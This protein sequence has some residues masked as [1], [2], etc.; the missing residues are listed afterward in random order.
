MSFLFFFNDTATTEIYTLSLHDALPIS[1]ARR[2]P[3]WT[4]SPGACVS[5]SAASGSPT[6][7]RGRRRPAT[8]TSDAPRAPADPR[9]A[10]P[11][12]VLHLHRVTAGVVHERAR[13]VHVTRSPARERAHD[14]AELAPA[15]GQL[16]LGPGRVGRVEAPRDEPALLQELQPVRQD[17]RRDPRE[18]PREVREAPRPREQVAH[19]Q[20]G[21]AVA[22]H[23]QRLRHRARL[24]VTLRHGPSLAEL[25]RKASH[26]KITSHGGRHDHASNLRPAVP[27]QLGP[28]HAHRPLARGATAGGAAARVGVVAAAL[29]PRVSPPGDGVPRPDRGGLLPPARVRGPGRLRRP[30]R[31]APGA[32]RDRRAAVP[33]A[34]RAPA[35]LALQRRGDRRPRQ[36]ARPRPPARREP[37]RGVLHPDVRGAGSLRHA[38]DDLRDAR[39]TRALRSPR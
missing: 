19:E 22:D 11:A 33:V 13:A 23:L 26:Y 9:G 39:P 37:G 10:V 2:A 12:E 32:P 35:G 8:P 25:D 27:A 18:A 4:R 20:E 21:P 16:V 30:A 36:R 3:S 34:V 28:V 24:A 1:F 17:V 7:A 38:R 15:V 5:R 31:R 6:L 29:P 14:D